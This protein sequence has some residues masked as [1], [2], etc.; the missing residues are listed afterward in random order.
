MSAGQDEDALMDDA[1]PS[2]QPIVEDAENDGDDGEVP[3]EDYEEEEEEE[4]EEPQR[5]KL[6]STLVIYYVLCCVVL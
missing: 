4:E 1:P 5:V 3:G 6:V 2:H